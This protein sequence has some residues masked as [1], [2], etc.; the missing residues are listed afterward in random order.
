M[1]PLELVP[2]YVPSNDGLIE[3][4]GDE[5]AREF[6]CEVRVRLPWFDPEDA[7]DSERG[8]Y[9]STELL[10]ALLADPDASDALVLGVTGV[11]LFVP[12]LTF[13]YGEAQLDGRAAVVSLHRLRTEA[14][15]LAPDPALLHER[16]YK[17]A[18]HEL[19]HVHGLLHCADPSCV[20]RASSYV[21]QV[22]GKTREFCDACV[23]TIE[24]HVG[25]AR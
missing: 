20:M 9:D 12:V 11:D 10:A 6:R 22:D 17:E 3:R 15:G 19:G 23:A 2:F 14:Y 24:A 25:A 18:A 16:L 13:V 1:R 21:E 7:Y 5:L 4:L 8:Q